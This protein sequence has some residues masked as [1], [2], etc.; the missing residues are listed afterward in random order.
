MLEGESPNRRTATVWT[1]IITD[2]IFFV[3][4]FFCFYPSFLSKTRRLPYQ[5]TAVSIVGTV[6]TEVDKPS[7]TVGNGLCAV[8][9][10][11][12]YNL[13]GKNAITPRYVIPSER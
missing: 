7:L 2:G 5:E 10:R 12:D 3:N 6:G 1:F 13:C 11:G 4:R 9:L 8:P